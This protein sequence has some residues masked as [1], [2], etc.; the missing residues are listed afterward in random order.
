MEP[1]TDD[2]TTSRLT[3]ESLMNLL[4]KVIGLY[5]LIYGV[6]NCIESVYVWYL[7][8]LKDMTVYTE[9]QSNTVLWG[10]AMLAIGSWLVA[11]SKWAT[12]LA[13][14]FDAPLELLEDAHLPDEAAEQ[15]DPPKPLTGAS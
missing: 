3:P 13:Y 6:L 12:R 14:S 1:R 15:I 4:V 9:S 5:W 2:A 8:R 10:V 7:G 11:Y